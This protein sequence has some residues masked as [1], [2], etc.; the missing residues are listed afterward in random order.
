VKISVGARIEGCTFRDNTASFGGAVY[1]A[2]SLSDALPVLSIVGCTFDQNNA[3]WGGAIHGESGAAPTISHC[4]FLANSATYGAAIDSMFAYYTVPGGAVSVDDCLFAGNVAVQLGGAIMMHAY[5]ISKARV[6]QSTF[7][8]NNAQHGGAIFLASGADVTVL[9]SI[10]WSDTA[11]TGNEIASEGTG[12][13]TQKL[14]VAWSDVHGGLAA[15]SHP[16]GQVT[17]GAGNIDLDPSFADPDGPDNDPTTF[18]DNDYRL[19]LASPCIDAADNSSI[20]PDSNDIDGDGD[21]LEPTPLDLALQPRRT[22]VASVPDTGS[23]IAP[24]VD[25]GAYE[26]R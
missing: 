7:V 14:L 23:G 3:A 4:A 24:I 18:A 11:T 15:V 19:S 6:T 22:D 16:V 8:A 2:K 10:L 25:M 12:Y 5:G 21:V 26:H 20:P 13:G 17:W 9:N 1:L